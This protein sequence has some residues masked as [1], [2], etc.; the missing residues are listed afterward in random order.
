MVAARLYLVHACRCCLVTGRK[1]IEGRELERAQLPLS[2][3]RSSFCSWPSPHPK[4]NT[5]THTHKDTLSAFL[6]LDCHT[7]THITK[8]L[9]L[10]S[11]PDGCSPPVTEEDEERRARRCRRDDF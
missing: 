5:D 6:S 7:H 9:S 3:H 1:Q 10:I 4:P 2:F 8:A 11:S